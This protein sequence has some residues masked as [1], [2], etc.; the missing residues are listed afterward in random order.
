MIVPT[1]NQVN[2][3]EELR[4]DAE[5]SEG[6]GTRVISNCK[7]LDKE[8]PTQVSKPKLVIKTREEGGVSGKTSQIL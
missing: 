2:E 5:G 1:A 3:A 8:G 6:E 4:S 7:Y